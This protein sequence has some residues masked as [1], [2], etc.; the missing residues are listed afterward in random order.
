MKM[1]EVLEI[2]KIYDSIKTAK[3]PLKTTYKFARL[4]KRIEEEI[5][6]YQERFA[7]IVAEFGVKENG[8]YLLTEDGS[9]IKVTPG[10]EAEC[11]LQVNEL[12]NLDV[13]I[14]DIRFSISE[15]ESLELSISEMAC[16]LSLI[17]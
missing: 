3:L 16:L 12:Q 1:Y 8:Q 11:N 2:A 14:N 6:F 7:K 17:E 4:M 15:F 10:R 13:E 9:S 5:G